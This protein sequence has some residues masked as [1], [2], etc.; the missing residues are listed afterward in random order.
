MNKKWSLLFAVATLV[1]FSI[2]GCQKPV[3][4]P[5]PEPEPIPIPEPGPEPDPVE[6][7][8]FKTSYDVPGDRIFEVRP[9][10]I[11]HLENPNAVAAPAEIKLSVRTDKG[12]VVTTVDMNKEIAA[13]ITEAVTVT[14]DTDLE[15]GF[16]KAQCYVNS[17]PAG[18][19]AFGISPFDIV[20]APD[21]QPDFD[22]FWQ[23]AKDQLA[24][25]DMDATLREVESKSTAQQKV[26]LV[27]MKSVPDGLE[28]EPVIIH[29]YYL[30]PQDN[31]GKKYPVLIHFFGYD[32]QKPGKLSCPSGS[33]APKY[34]EFY[35]STRGQMINNRTADK[36]GD[37]FPEDYVNT[38][39][40]WFAFNFG[41]RDGYYYRGAFMD[42]VQA[43]RFM[44]TRPTSD[45]NNIFAEGSSQGGAFSYAAAALSDYPFRAIA[46]CVAFLGDFADYFKIVSWPG[47]TAKKNKGSMTDE[48]M[49]AF[50]SYFDTK[51]LATR[52]SCA[53]IACSGLVD[54]TCP[55]HTNIAPFNN[56]QTPESDKEYYFYPK[57]GHEIPAGWSNKW[58][59][60][61]N[62]HMQ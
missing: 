36:R 53:V 56:L 28:G 17:Y 5:G 45:M 15:P 57:M 23:D 12:A 6:L 47:D 58:G 32:D 60:F 3:P 43:V 41:N 1:V 61:F 29:G 54:G 16:Y 27:E 33:A 31:S 18:S 49:Y 2:A 21:K 10:V 50:L 52:I 59:S 42:C 20:S 14:T 30:E 39:G 7:E 38:Y 55:P 9:Q 4:V 19:F 40:D 62:A 26:Y 24:S 8:P 48:Q 22:Q 35:L 51:N 37:G 46:P 25:I 13:S 11:L 34:A 44:A